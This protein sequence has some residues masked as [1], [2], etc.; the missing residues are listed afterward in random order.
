MGGGGW[1]VNAMPQPLYPR[2]REPASIVH[3]YPQR[4]SERVR[5][6]SHPPGFDPP[7]LQPVASRYTDW[8][9]LAPIPPGRNRI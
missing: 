1:L 3:V 7:N 9:I 2:E 8:D 5:K 4:R 6:I